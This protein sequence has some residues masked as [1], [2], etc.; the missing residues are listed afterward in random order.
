[1]MEGLVWNLNTAE[2]YSLVPITLFL[3]YLIDKVSPLSYK[4][5]LR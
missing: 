3:K 5:I 4:D 2:L 1:M